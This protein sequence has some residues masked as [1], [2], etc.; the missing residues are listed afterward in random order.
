MTRT[1]LT[2]L[3]TWATRGVTLLLLVTLA[4]GTAGLPVVQHLCGES[5]YSSTHWGS[6]E[7][8]G[9]A[10]EGLAPVAAPAEGL[11]LQAEPCCRDHVQM[12]TAQERLAVSTRIMASAPPTLGMEL[13]LLPA[14]LVL[15]LLVPQA[16]STSL[17]VSGYPPQAQGT[18]LWL[19]LQHILC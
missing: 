12:L 15:G 9:M 14:P 19:E 6:A 7:G 16:S 13:S 8:C 4:L 5:V 18:P 11:A 2:R 10:E 1:H 17:E 3:R